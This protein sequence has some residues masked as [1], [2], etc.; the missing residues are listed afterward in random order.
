VRGRGGAA[1]EKVLPQL[2]VRDCQRPREL[3]V[4]HE[5][6]PATDGR[7]TFHA[8]LVAAPGV[9]GEVA[10]YR[11]TFD[12]GEAVETTSPDVVHDYAGR[13]QE[14]AVT[15]LLV[16]CEARTSDGHEVVGRDALTLENPLFAARADERAP[17]PI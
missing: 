5:V 7:V 9:E 12:D 2:A 11:W 6:D 16:A 1:V 8:Q 17:V 3:L 4:S 14:T 13:A 10:R 15:S